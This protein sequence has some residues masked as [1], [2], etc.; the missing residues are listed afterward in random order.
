MNQ[1]RFAIVGGM[2]LDRKE[3]MRSEENCERE[4]ERLKGS[5]MPRIFFF[6]FECSYFHY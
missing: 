6:S 5:S 1:R 4:F 3:G 2:Y